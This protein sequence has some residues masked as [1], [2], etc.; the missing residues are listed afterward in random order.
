VVEDSRPE[1]VVEVAGARTCFTKT[2]P[3]YTSYPW[4]PDS[5]S[6]D[7]FQLRLMTPQAVADALSPPGV[8]GGVVSAGVVA[9]A[10]FEYAEKTPVDPDA[11]TR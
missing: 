7:A 4:T 3:R 5:L 9:L 6:V 11:R 2:P 10:T 1:S 8:E